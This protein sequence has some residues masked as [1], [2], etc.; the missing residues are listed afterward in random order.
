MSVT[1]DNGLPGVTVKAVPLKEAGPS[2]VRLDPDLRL[3]PAFALEIKG[4]RH[5]ARN[6]GALFLSEAGA[7]LF[8]PRRS[9]RR[10]LGELRSE[11]PPIVF[12]TPESMGSESLGRMWNLVLREKREAEVRKALQILEPGLE[13]IVFQTGESSSRYSPDRSSV[14]VSTKG[15]PRRFPLGSMGD[16]MRRLLALSVSLIRAQGG[17]LFIDEVDTGFHHSIM[18]DMWRLIIDT[19][20]KYKI[21]VFT[22]THSLDCT[23][24]LAEVCMT[25]PATAAFVSAHK[26]D[27]RLENDVA[28]AGMEIVAAVHHEMELR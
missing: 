16:G 7:L 14:L 25:N 1:G 20:L 9:P 3:L 13:D 15:T 26:I 6:E 11:G 10:Y 5:R 21:Q 23:K 24:G 19:A 22:T 12:I 4:G 28:Y 8:D 18:A 17:F 2:I 27:R